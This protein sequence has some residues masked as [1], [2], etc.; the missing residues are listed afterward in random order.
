MEAISI[1]AAYDAAIYNGLWRRFERSESLPGRFLLS[2]SKFQDAKYGENPD[3]R[4]TIYSID[5]VEEHDGLGAAGR[6]H[7]ILQQLPRHRELVRHP[8]R[9]RGTPAAATVKHGNISGFAFAPDISEAYELAHAC[10]PQADFGGTVILNRE[11]DSETAMLIGK[12]EGVRTRRSTR[13]SSS[14]PRSG[15][16][17]STCSSRNRR[18]R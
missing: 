8:R 7:A 1:T 3:Q 9:V 2:A 15:P 14:R 16:M 18:R 17:R 12:N 5:G 11:I 4:A 6:R 10:D 13:R